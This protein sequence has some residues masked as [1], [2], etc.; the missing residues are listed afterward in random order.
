MNEKPLFQLDWLDIKILGFSFPHSTVLK[1]QP[2]L[3]FSVGS[4]NPNLGSTCKASAPI[5]E[6]SPQIMVNSCKL[7]NGTQHPE[8]IKWQLNA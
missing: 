3:A 5:T 6:P 8:H 1:L 2:C 4:E 7:M